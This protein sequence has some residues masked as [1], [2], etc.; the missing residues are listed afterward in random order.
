[1]AYASELAGGGPLAVTLLDEPLVLARI[2]GEVSAFR[3][4]C[5]HRGTALSLGS[6]SEEGLRCGYHGRTYN[7]ASR[8]IRIPARPDL[9]IPSR[10]RLI[11]S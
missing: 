8:R 7:G 5:V 2:D 11:R 6:V 1:M 4:I 3:D 10:A 9:K